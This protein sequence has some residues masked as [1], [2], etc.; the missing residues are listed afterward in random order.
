MQKFI[1]GDDSRLQLILHHR[2]TC[3]SKHDLGQMA[4]GWRDSYGKDWVSIAWQATICPGLASV[5][6][7]CPADIDAATARKTACLKCRNNGY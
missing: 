4:V 2:S 1:R 5:G 3:D 7:S 6:R